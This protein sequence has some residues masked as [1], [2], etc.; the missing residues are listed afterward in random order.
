MKS[1]MVLLSLITSVARADVN[2]G[3]KVDFAVS[4]TKPVFGI[5]MTSNLM[6]IT[7]SIDGNALSQGKNVSKVQIRFADKTTG[8]YLSDLIVV[9]DFPNGTIF[10][11]A[12]AFTTSVTG[13]DALKVQSM[14]KTSAMLIGVKDGENNIFAGYVDLGQYCT[15]DK[16]QFL[17][18]ESGATGCQSHT[19]Y[20]VPK[21][22]ACLSKLAIDGAW[23]G[24][25]S[26][27]IPCLIKN[28]EFIKAIAFLCLK[29]QS[30]IS[31]PYLKYVDLKAKL[32]AAFKAYQSSTD[33][34]ARL[35]ASN[36]M[37]YAKRQ[38]SAFGYEEEIQ[39]AQ[40]AAG[41]AHEAC[42]VP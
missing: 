5:Q 42:H 14:L 39:Q 3:K 11:G 21:L 17:N 26:S 15:S 40:Y 6:A 23:S 19:A 22:S 30:S 2:L 38:L 13:V 28:T 37:E 18:I 25:I 16:S 33:A 10:A 9:G 36:D 1:L 35:K 20:K 4:G 7:F 32:D 12:Q 8:E 29:D 41:G 31:A 27:E 34:N 24:K